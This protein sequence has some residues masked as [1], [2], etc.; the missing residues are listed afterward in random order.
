MAR[1]KIKRPALA[2]PKVILKLFSRNDSHALHWIWLAQPA[3]QIRL[4]LFQ[5][6]HLCSYCYN[7][8]PDCDR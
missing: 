4:F 1:E 7:S 3:I 2:R 6:C 8:H 5:L